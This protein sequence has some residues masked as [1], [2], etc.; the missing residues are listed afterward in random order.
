MA[1]EVGVRGDEEDEGE[2]VEGEGEGEGEGAHFT[3][4]LRFGS[5]SA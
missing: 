4:T 5:I 3:S 1:L 2:E